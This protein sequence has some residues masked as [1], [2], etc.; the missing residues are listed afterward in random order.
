MT[1]VD[2]GWLAELGSKIYSLKEDY[3]GTGDF[4]PALGVD[5][6]CH[7][8]SGYGRACIGSKKGEKKME[9]ASASLV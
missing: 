4:F 6:G 9:N 3:V 5:R 8:I 7:G 1:A 2:G